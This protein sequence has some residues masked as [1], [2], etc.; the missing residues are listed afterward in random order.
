[1]PDW[2]VGDLS[3]LVRILE[4]QGYAVEFHPVREG[5]TWDQWRGLTEQRC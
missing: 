2:D 3:G 4:E 5:H 1:M